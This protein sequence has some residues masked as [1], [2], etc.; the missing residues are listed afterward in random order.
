MET[1]IYAL[2]IWVFL[3][4]GSIKMFFDKC[5]SVFFKGGKDVLYST[6][7]DEEINWRKISLATAKEMV[8]SQLG[9]LREK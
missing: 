1:I 2:L 7:R 9:D 6:M 8:A 5:L 3:R 4:E